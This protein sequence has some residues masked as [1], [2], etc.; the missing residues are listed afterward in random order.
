MTLLS[1]SQFTL[2]FTRYVGLLRQRQVAALSELTFS[3][4]RGEIVALVGASGAGKSLLA[5]ALFGILPPNAVTAGLLLLD[6]QALDFGPNADHRGRRMGLL[7]QSPSHLDP[8]V[9]CGRQLSWAAARSGRRADTDELASDL[10]QF[11]LS[12]DVLRLYPHELSG[13]MARRVLLAMAT[14]GKPDLVVA[15]E[16]TSGLDPDSSA[17]VLGHLHQLANG[18]KGVLL[19]THD[20]SH[21]LPFA[22]RVAILRSGRLAGLEPSSAFSG[23]GEALHSDYARQL[24]RAMPDNSFFA[25]L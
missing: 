19:I 6:G 23:D 5:H 9:R 10:E 11:G 7:P 2:S 24:W 25:G 22:Q 8:L 15:D 21:A 3:L 12:A 13:G 1:I 18:G 20:L 4:A 17:I 16:P 14:V